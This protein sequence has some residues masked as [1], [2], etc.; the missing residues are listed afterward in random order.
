MIGFAAK[1]EQGMFKRLAAM[2]GWTVSAAPS[3]TELD[4]QW[5]PMQ[6]DNA[7][8]SASAS[9]GLNANPNGQV[10]Q[11]PAT[12]QDEQQNK[13]RWQEAMASPSEPSIDLKP[14]SFKQIA[15]VTGTLNTVGSTLTR[16]DE[17]GAP[18]VFTYNAAFNAYLYHCDKGTVQ[19]VV[20]NRHGKWEWRGENND[21]RR[22]YEIYHSVADNSGQRDAGSSGPMA[23]E[24]LSAGSSRLSAVIA[25]NGDS[26]NYHY[27]KN[28]KLACVVT[29]TNNQAPLG[30]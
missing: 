19:S 27:G 18:T 2:F 13:Q 20:A 17:N 30:F 3:Y 10:Q 14:A 21:A 23:H 5:A 24:Q 9:A 28:G 4:P 16:I 6:A 11:R 15:N 26:T 22:A 29:V 1:R 12:S 7:S 25:S 8:A